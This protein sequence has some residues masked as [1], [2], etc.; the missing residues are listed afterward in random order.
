MATI[1][2][3]GQRAGVQAIE[4]LIRELEANKAKL[5]KTI[6]NLVEAKVDQN[7]ENQ[8]IQEVHAWIVE[9]S[10]VETSV[11]GEAVDEVVAS[12]LEEMLG[13]W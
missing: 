3:I 6:A 9:H 13:A 5:A 4:A 7:D 2:Q 10:Q 8:T 12:V 11:L 1:N